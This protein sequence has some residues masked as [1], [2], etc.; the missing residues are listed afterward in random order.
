VMSWNFPF[1]GNWGIGAIEFKP[2]AA[3]GLVGPL[4][5]GGRL[6]HGSLLRGG[7]RVP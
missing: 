2:V 3:A 7:V 6:L 1:G 4:I 5:R